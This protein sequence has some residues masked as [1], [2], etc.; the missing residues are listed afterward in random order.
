MCLG[1]LVAGIWGSNP[2]R[3]MDVCLCVYILR[4]CVLV[5]A[6][7]TSLSP[8][9]WSPTTCIIRLGKPRRGGRGTIKAATP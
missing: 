3:G 5:E 8:V 7:A 4:C 2:A 9:Q 6:F 1:R